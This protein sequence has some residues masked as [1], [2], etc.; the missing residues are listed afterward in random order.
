MKNPTTKTNLPE[1]N[2]ITLLQNVLFVVCLIIIVLRATFTEAP[3]PQSTQ[4]Q[5]AI[6]DT[7]YS[8]ALSGLLIFALLL[9]VLAKL[10]TGQFSF[11]HSAVEIGLLVFLAAAVIAS[12]FASNKRAA[13]NASLTLLAPVCMAILLIQLLN[14]H[15]KIK[16]LLIAITSLGIVASWQSSEQFF[17]S[18]NIMLDEYRDDP[19]TI[20]EPLGIQPGTLNHMLLEHRL[21]SKDVR[22]S[23]TTSNSAGSFAVL[24]SFAAIALLAERL[25]NRKSSPAP[26]LNFILPVLA[27]AAVLFGLFLTRSKGAIAAFLIA[28]AIFTL[29][30]RSSRPKISKNIILVII[31]VGLCALVPVII[32]YGLKFGR[33]PGGNSM[34]VRWQYWQA[35]SKMILDYPLTGVGGGNFPSFYPHYKPSAASETVSDPHCFVLSIISQYGPLGLLGFLIIVLVP[36]LAHLPYRPRH[37]RTS[38]RLTIPE[39]DNHLHNRRRHH[40]V[41]RAPLHR[42]DRHRRLPL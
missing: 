32:W 4:I 33:L 28:L 11:R 22:A 5:A 25:K 16:L 7:V 3:S 20:L 13:I 42:A 39:T 27:L 36:L 41:L 19:N 8:L 17:V 15:A 18:N 12:F 35:S 24:A 40:Y 38:S 29:L 1:N 30:L 34:L 26:L 31:L 21:Y 37:T 10:W 14:S 9:W 6:N 2:A 23:F